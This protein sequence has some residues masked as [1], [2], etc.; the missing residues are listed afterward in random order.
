MGIKSK[1]TTRNKNGTKT[2][3]IKQKD[4]SGKTTTYRDGMFGRKTE[5]VKFYSKKK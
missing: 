3:R 5:S 2:E 1:E 4:G